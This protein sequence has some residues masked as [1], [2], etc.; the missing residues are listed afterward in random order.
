MW[1]CYFLSKWK[2]RAKKCSAFWRRLAFHLKFDIWKT[3]LHQSGNEKKLHALKAATH[4]K[5]H[6]KFNRKYV[7]IMF[8][9]CLDISPETYRVGRQRC[10]W[11]AEEEKTRNIMQRILDSATKAKKTTQSDG[12]KHREFASTFCA[13]FFFV[14]FRMSVKIPSRGTIF[15]IRHFKQ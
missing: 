1:R 14:R 9:A 8:A 12:N 15:A 3:N 10:R 13:Q 4:F 5:C 11:N 6:I 2:W 7:F